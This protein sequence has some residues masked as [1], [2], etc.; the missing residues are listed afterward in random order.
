MQI[1]NFNI[2]T[3]FDLP[4]IP[5]RRFDWSA[6]CDGL[7]EWKIGRGETELDA[8]VDLRNQLIDDGVI[9]AIYYVQ[10]EDSR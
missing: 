1:G 3:N 10:L 5:D 9:G 6:W 7:E 4:P 2:K 8:I